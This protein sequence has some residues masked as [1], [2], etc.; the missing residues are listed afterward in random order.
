MSTQFL[1]TENDSL[2]ELLDRSL[3]V[4]KQTL[5]ALGPEPYQYLEATVDLLEK[6]IEELEVVKVGDKP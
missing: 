5:G 1:Q 2:N 6:I 4:H 3:S